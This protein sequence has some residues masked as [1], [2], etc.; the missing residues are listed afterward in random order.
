MAFSL[1]LGSLALSCSSAPQRAHVSLALSSLGLVSPRLVS[2]RLASLRFAS[3]CLASSGLASCLLS[4]PLASPQLALTLSSCRD[5]SSVAQSTVEPA[6][7]STRHRQL[8][9]RLLACLSRGLSRAHRPPWART[10]LL[11]SARRNLP[12]SPTSAPTLF[13]PPGA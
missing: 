10:R 7:L 12:G 11:S 2:L 8:G 4:S 1:S 6:R 3:P 5:S 9:L 13:S